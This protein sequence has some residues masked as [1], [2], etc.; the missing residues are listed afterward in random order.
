MVSSVPPVNYVETW[1]SLVQIGHFWSSPLFLWAN[2]SCRL[3]R[4]IDLNLKYAMY[5][6]LGS[7]V[8]ADILIAGS[9]CYTLTK[10]RTG[11][12]KW[13]EGICSCS[14]TQSLLLGAKPWSTRWCSMLLTHVSCS[15]AY[16]EEFVVWLTSLDK[17]FLHRKCC[18]SVI[19]VVV[20]RSASR[21]CAVVCFVTY[22]VWPQ[23]F[24]FIGIYFCLNKCESINIGHTELSYSL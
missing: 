17:A 12:D 18:W 22:I 21:L 24:I 13:A 9:L 5:G 11:F 15:L 10:S 16:L 3:A 8:V 19:N 6:A 7:L 20:W 14:T 23:E 4:S 1:Y 2:L